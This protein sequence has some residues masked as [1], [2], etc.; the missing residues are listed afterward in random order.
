MGQ[1]LALVHNSNQTITHVNGN[2]IGKVVLSLLTFAIMSL[3]CA[4]PAHADSIN[5]SFDTSNATLRGCN[6]R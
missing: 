1:Y 2:F 3:F 4:T 6:K 5:L